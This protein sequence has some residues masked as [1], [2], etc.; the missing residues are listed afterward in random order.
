MSTQ[1]GLALLSALFLNLTAFPLSIAAANDKPAATV[2][3]PQLQFAP[4]QLSVHTGATVLFTN[5]GDVAH[6]VTASDKS[7]DSGD[8]APG[9]S[10]SYTFTKAGTYAYICAYHS[11]MKGTVTVTDAGP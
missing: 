1:I 7:F 10:W 5:D 4:A 2:R 3:M 8:L 6:T 9:K 11:W